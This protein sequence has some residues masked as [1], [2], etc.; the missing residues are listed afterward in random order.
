MA[1][2]FEDGMQASDVMP[3]LC[4]TLRGLRAQARKVA[5]LHCELNWH[6]HEIAVQALIQH[7][8]G[9]QQLPFG[10]NDQ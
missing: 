7:A 10:A 1:Q 2:A 8:S 9:P 4:L 6:P 3:L 5:D